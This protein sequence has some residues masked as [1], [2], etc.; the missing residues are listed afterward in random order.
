MKLIHKAEWFEFDSPIGEPHID[1]NPNEKYHIERLVK[2]DGTIIWFGQN[3]NWKKEPKKN[4]TVLTTND[5]AKP[6]EKYLPEIVYGGDRTYFKPCVM[7]IYE[8]Y[9]KALEWW[10]HLPIQNLIEPLDSWSGYTAKYYPDR[11]SCYG[12]TD[13]EILHIYQS[14]INNYNNSIQ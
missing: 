4:W 6:L 5:Y 8:K 11:T 7:P 1:W 10:N 14:E 3:T 13:D 2:Q 12:L 9:Y